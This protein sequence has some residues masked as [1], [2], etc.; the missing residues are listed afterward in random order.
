MKAFKSWAVDT[1]VRAVKT[2]A[3]TAVAIVTA[4][5]AGVTDVAWMH[6]LDVAGLAAII[7]VLHNL[8][9]LNIKTNDA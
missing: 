5:T 6:V 3:Q 7:T 1:G 8:A 4:N 9:S 2:A